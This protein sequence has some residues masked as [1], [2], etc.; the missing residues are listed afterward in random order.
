MQK[1]LQ[2]SNNKSISYTSHKRDVIENQSELQSLKMKIGKIE[3]IKFNKSYAHGE[4]HIRAKEQEIIAGGFA[5]KGVSIAG[6][7]NAFIDRSFNQSADLNLSN[8][9]CVSQNPVQNNNRNTMI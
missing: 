2:F 6:F 1:I 9:M 3:Q 5:K 4:V 7:N 8:S